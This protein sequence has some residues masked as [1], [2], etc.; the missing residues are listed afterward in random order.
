[1]RFQID[2][3]DLL[4]RWW[5][6]TIWVLFGVSVILL[7]GRLAIRLRLHHRIFWDDSLAILG[8][9]FLLAENVLIVLIL[10]YVFMLV[11]YLDG[12]IDRPDDFEDQIA[13]MLKMSFAIN[14]L[15]ASSLWS[16]KASFMALMWRLV[17]NLATF[18]RVWWAI[19]VILAVTYCVVIALE[20]IACAK[21][22]NSTFL[23]PVY[24]YIYLYISLLT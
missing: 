4:T 23:F 10:P 9:L 11:Y 19:I 1:M 24:I 13:T 5:Q 8:T 16:V 6:V 12:Q 14:I 18:R 21:L 22:Y 15:F 20:P 3:A 17:R 2:R 7:A